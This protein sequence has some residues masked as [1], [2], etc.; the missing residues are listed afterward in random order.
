[1]H[2]NNNNDAT[3]VET[4]GEGSQHNL[5]N[6][7]GPGPNQTPTACANANLPQSHPPTAEQHQALA[8]SAYA[9]AY[10]KQLEYL[11]TQQQ[12]TASQ[13]PT[14]DPNFPKIEDFQCGSSYYNYPSLYDQAQYNYMAQLSQMNFYNQSLYAGKAKLSQTNPDYTPFTTMNDPQDVAGPSGQTG[15]SAA[16]GACL[17]AGN[18]HQMNINNPSHL[19]PVKAEKLPLTSTP[20]LL[21]HA[22]YDYSAVG[23]MAHLGSEAA[24]GLSVSAAAAAAAGMPCSLEVNNHLVANQLSVN[25]SP[26]L[27]VPV[28]DNIKNKGVSPSVFKSATEFY[29][30]T[31]NMSTNANTVVAAVAALQKRPRGTRRLR[32]AYTNAQLLD[33]EKEFQ[34]NKYL[35]RP[36]RIEIASLLSLT[37]RQVKVWFQNRRMKYKREKAAAGAHVPTTSSKRILSSD[38]ELI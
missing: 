10:N 3:N 7:A 28:P 30:N 19:S 15:H 22:Y 12:H 14:T 32:T 6:S 31:P 29:N 34:F 36:R 25:S 5:G 37:E 23:S 24:L 35:C 33:L 9:E 26:H 13:Y 11:K 27:P 2:N 38:H 16:S 18:H 21:G 4:N 8:A 1:M 20:N 17:G